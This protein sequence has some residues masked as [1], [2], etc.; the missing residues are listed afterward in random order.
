MNADTPSPCHSYWHDNG[1][2][3]D[4]TEAE[5]PIEQG[6]GGGDD[7]NRTHDLLLAKQMLYQLSYVPVNGIP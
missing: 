2:A 3:I 7:G 5:T 6:F 1:A 4:R